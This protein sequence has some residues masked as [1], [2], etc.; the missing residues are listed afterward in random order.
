MLNEEIG[1]VEVDEDVCPGDQAF[2]PT[3]T[4]S[5]RRN[6]LNEL[7]TSHLYDPTHTVYIVFSNQYTGSIGLDFKA[8]F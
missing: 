5:G 7:S 8:K 1:I 4:H 3:G 2:R 6:Q